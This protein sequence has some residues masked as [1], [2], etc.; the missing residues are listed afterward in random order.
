MEDLVRQLEAALTTAKS[1]LA[2]QTPSEQQTSEEIVEPESPLSLYN[3][4]VKNA[5]QFLK[6]YDLEGAMNLYSRA[7]S[8]AQTIDSNARIVETLT[9]MGLIA[10]RQEKYVIAFTKFED[11]GNLC[12][13][14]RL[15]EWSAKNLF[16]KAILCSMA[17]ESMT[18][19]RMRID[20]YEDRLLYKA[21]FFDNLRRMMGAIDR[22][23]SKGFTEEIKEIDNIMKL[24]SWTTSV[25]LKIRERCF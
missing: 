17:T 1:L 11:A 6:N 24:D 16:F 10:G 12:L 19:C 21:T 13:E 7:L 22:K 9:E 3:M 23:D 14:S 25:I 20:N 5:K 15:L 2:A 4:Y 8:E 18:V